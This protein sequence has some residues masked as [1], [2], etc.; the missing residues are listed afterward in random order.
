MTIG[1]LEAWAGSDAL[2]LCLAEAVGFAPEGAA[3]SDAEGFPP[4]EVAESDVDDGLPQPKRPSR[5]KTN[6]AG[7]I[8]LCRILILL[9]SE[10]LQV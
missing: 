8:V 6:R 1:G 5:P 2:W 4:E 10:A 9:S 3:E 7:V